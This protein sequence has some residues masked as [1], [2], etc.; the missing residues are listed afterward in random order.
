MTGRSAPRGRL[1]ILRGLRLQKP[2]QPLP[3]GQ[4]LGG[5]IR[6]LL[7]EG[8]GSYHKGI[9]RFRLMILR[10]VFLL[11]EIFL[12]VSSLFVPSGLP[13]GPLLPY[14]RTRKMQY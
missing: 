6:G 4:V 14:T 5:A 9:W 3:E 11:T 8:A 10:T 12:N 1:V 7:P 13:G 2:L